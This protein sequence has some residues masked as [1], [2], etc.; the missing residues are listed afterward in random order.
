MAS[1]LAFW[2]VSQATSGGYM[3]QM[4][5]L[6][7]G[8]AL[9]STK[10]KALFASCAKPCGSSSCCEQQAGELP[11][12]PGLDRGPGCRLLWAVGTGLPGELSAGPGL[13]PRP[14]CKLLLAE[15]TG[16]G[17]SRAQHGS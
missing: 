7:N 6:A 15:G 4:A 12:G 14:S 16:Q 3:L 13:D 8:C 17:V 5:V 9:A 11:V 1:T 10:N 2:W